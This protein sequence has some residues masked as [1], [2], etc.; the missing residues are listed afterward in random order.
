MDYQSRIANK[1]LLDKV[2]T[3]EQAAELIKSDMTLGFSGFTSAGYPKMVTKALAA[4]GEP[5]GLRILAGASTGEE[6]DGELARAGLAALRVPF[7]SN[8]YMRNGINSGAVKYADQ[9]LSHFSRQVR[10]GLW[11]KVDFAIV[12]CCAVLEDGSLVPTM[13]AGATDA[14]V[15]AAE[16]VIVELN[17][18]VPEKIIG[19]HDFF[20]PSDGKGGERA[21]P[22][23]T[24]AQRMGKC[25]IDCTPDKIA[26][27]VISD[28]PDRDPSF[29]EPDEVSSKIAGHIINLLSDEIA[30]G[31]LPENI[32]IQSGVG[33]VANAVLYGL[34]SDKFKQFNMYTEVMQEGAFELLL[35]GKIGEVSAA[36]FSL[37]QE[38]KKKF[39]DSIDEL[40]GK[41]VLRPQDMS[42]HCSVIK[43][44]S[45]VAMNTAIEA[46]IYGNIN[47]THIMGSGIMN[48]IGGSGDFSRHSGLTIFM[49]PSTAKGGKISSIVPM[50]SHV[51]STEHDVDIIVT[52]HGA[53]DLRGKSPRER[54]EIMIECC[55]DPSYRPA[56]RK[57]FEDAC[58]AAPGQQ[59]PHD[60]RHAFDWHIRF[61]ETGSMR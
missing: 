32:T 50:V 2:M 38:S 29:T 56:L 13:S 17:V 34:D 25:S 8:K 41:M 57:Y 11:G 3:A 24:P 59:T 31:R 49:T 45:I 27:I 43:R 26:A 55:C 28:I 40:K 1:Q 9:H 39:F 44:M 22:D 42:N 19:I 37:T 20:S 23:F 21:I 6:I 58:K 48:G 12:D 33:A 47:S 52:E 30:A 61:M 10:R 51:D 16:K 60:L 35:K 46:D 5:K 54:A 4:K 7:N 18:T 36:A 53:A 15:E 14:L